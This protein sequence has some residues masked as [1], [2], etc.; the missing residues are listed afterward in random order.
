LI[1]FEVA[2]QRD[3]RPTASLRRQRAA[4]REPDAASED[5]L[6]PTPRAG[7]GVEEDL[8]AEEL[9]GAREEVAD[10]D[11]PGSRHVA[12][13]GDRLDVPDVDADSEAC[14]R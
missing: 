10:L 8:D 7:I 11:R 14:S 4:D 1:D 9:V 3:P 6:D 5:R 12:D 13:V 2:Q